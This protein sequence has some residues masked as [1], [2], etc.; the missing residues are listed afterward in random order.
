MSYFFDNYPEAL[1]IIG[2]KFRGDL[3]LADVKNEGIYSSRIL[4]FFC[5][6]CSNNFKS[7]IKHIY[8][9]PFCYSC[10][11]SFL[12]ASPIKSLINLIQK[13]YK[14]T[15]SYSEFCNLIINLSNHDKGFIQ[16]YH[17]K[18][19]F[20]NH[21]VHYNI[22]NIYYRV[23]EPVPER[24]NVSKI[25]LGTD[26]ILEHNDGK[27]SL[28][29]VKYRNTSDEKVSKTLTRDSIGKMGLEA[30]VLEKNNGNFHKF[31]LFSNTL[32]KPFNIREEENKY[33]KYIDMKVL[34]DCDWNMFKSPINRVYKPIS[35]IPPINREWQNKALEFVFNKGFQFNRKT[36]VAP[37]G[38]GKSLFANGVI[39]MK[40]QEKSTCGTCKSCDSDDCKGVNCIFEKS[41]CGTCKSCDIDDCKGVNCIFENKNF[42]IN[43]QNIYDRI[44]IVVPNLVLLSQI[45]ENIVNYNLDRNYK[46][47]GSD[48]SYNEENEDNFQVPFDLTT[49]EEDIKDFLQTKNNIIVISTYQSLMRV[50]NVCR[51]INYSFDLCIADEA[52]LTCYPKCARRTGFNIITEDNF[53]IK[54]ILFL[55]ATPKVFKDTD[56]EIFIDMSNEKVYGD[57]FVYSFKKA[58]EDKVISDYG[59]IIGHGEGEENKCEEFYAYFLCDCIVKYNIQSCLISSTTHKKSKTLYTNF[60]TVCEERKLDYEIILMKKLAKSEDKERVIMKIR[61]GKKIIV[62]NVK[63][64]GL[65][66]D[67]KNLQSVMLVGDRKSNTDIVQTV[68]RCLRTY[69]DKDIAYILLPCLLDSV[70][71]GI[72]NVKEENEKDDNKKGDKGE[73]GDK[74]VSKSYLNCRKVLLAM[75][76]VDEALFETVTA[77]MKSDEIS[78][79][80]IIKHELVEKFHKDNDEK[81]EFKFELDFY[82]RLGK[83]KQFSAK[84]K[85][86]LLKEYCQINNRI[87]KD[88]DIYKD[89]Q[90]GFFLRTI[91]D[92]KAHKEKAKKWL[93]E[94]SLISDSISKS[95][96]KKSSGR[97]DKKYVKVPIDVKYECL[98][99]FFEIEKRLPD[100]ADIVIIGDEAVNIQDIWRPIL[101]VCLEKKGKELRDRF[102]KFPIAKERFEIKEDKKVGKD[103]S[104]PTMKQKEKYDALLEYCKKE[105]KLPTQKIAYNGQPI[106]SFLNT[107]SLSRYKCLR[108]EIYRELRKISPEIAKKLDKRKVSN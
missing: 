52:H 39:G 9:S 62:F 108:E 23:V 76:S 102:S 50:Y 42:A 49:S 106:G 1:E 14:E 29:Q 45:F 86:N 7:S 16:E 37:C 35:R 90:I 72:E 34:S 96:N 107:L 92:G 100:D 17:C 31:Y 27:I 82:S 87:P 63:V 101:K 58:I 48:L 66:T 6:C 60:V 19:Y 97:G 10:Y 46:L 65:G 68:S 59:I 33:I 28:V 88:A 51:E 15:S 95:L 21:K 5:L 74:D 36:V 81:L 84:D 40:K 13:L 69:P 98:E 44:L 41:T 57:Q 67:I 99:N 25:D 3:T 20:E 26:I 12:H 22:K 103:Q 61:S 2:N 70:N 85:F 47:I 4:K 32:T 93:K 78:W 71:N 91:I 64:F 105:K 43:N 75:G 11:S 79:Q 77:K 54:N 94:L 18:R 55:T 24:L 30:I 83:I 38:A 73:K 80:R 56:R 104:K 8:N 53:N 89:I